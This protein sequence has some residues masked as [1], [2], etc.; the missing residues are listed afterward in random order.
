M[1]ACDRLMK[2][3]HQHGYDTPGNDLF[4]NVVTAVVKYLVEAGNAL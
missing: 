3:L 4:E 1:D 2:R